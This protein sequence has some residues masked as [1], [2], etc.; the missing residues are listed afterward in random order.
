MKYLLSV[1]VLSVAFASATANAASL[2][3]TAVGNNNFAIYLDSTGPVFD[4]F[5]IDVVAQPGI[6]FTGL[7]SG[8]GKVPNDPNTFRNRIID[9]DPL[10]GGKGWLVAGASTNANLV[11]YGTG[12]GGGVKVN[13]ATEAGGRLFLAN[14]LTSG[15]P[16]AGSAHAKALLT[17]VDAGV[18]VGTVAIDLP[19][20]EPAT[21]GMASMALVGL[22]AFRRRK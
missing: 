22:A 13:T 12:P 10:D 1:I 6:T 14:I 4:S 9:A 17:L 15:T 19:V 5:Q 8:A 3:A 11:T 21:V 16:S 2:S 18:T 20:P 7:S